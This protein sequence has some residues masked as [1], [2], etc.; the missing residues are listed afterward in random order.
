[1]DWTMKEYGDA[2]HNPLVIV[3]GDSSK[4]PIV[5]EAKVGV[6][7]ILNARGTKDPDGNNLT[8][9]WFYYQEAASAISKPVKP[10]E[11]VGERGETELGVRPKVRI[12]GSER[13]QATVLPQSEGV[14]HIVLEV[15]DDGEPSLISYRR[16]ILA[17][18]S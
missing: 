6:P 15:E 2:N 16:I 5:I 7:V 9:K 10:E 3:N 13:E 17:I 14:A 1:M 4:E 18:S 11:I 12:E 8:Y